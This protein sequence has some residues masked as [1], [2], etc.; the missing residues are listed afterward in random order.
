MSFFRDALR[1]LLRSPA[2][3]TAAIA[4][5][6]LGS[7]A[8]TAI[9][10][11]VDTTLVRPLPFPD[12]ERLA[13]VWFD[14]PGVDRRGSLSIPEA[15][16]LGVASSFDA[17]LVTSRVRAVVL[18]EDGAERLRGE[19]VNDGYFE[20]LGVRPVIGRLLAP[21]D[22]V[23]AAPSAI[24][25]SHGT[26]IRGFGGDPSVLG[27]TLRTERATYTVV[28]VAPRQFIGTIEQ[29]VVDFWIPLDKY[30]PQRL[31]RDRS[32]RY[33]WTIARLKPGI[34][35]A[36]AQDELNGIQQAW[37]TTYPG[38]YRQR[39][40]RIEPFGE[41]WRDGY[42]SAVGVLATAAGMLLA[43]AAINVGAL[44]LARV[45]DRRRELAVRAALGADRRRLVWL[46]FTEA[47]AIVVIGGALGACAGPLLLDSLL[48][49]SPVPLPEYLDL[50][51]NVGVLV[52]SCVALAV[53]GLFSGTAPALVGGRVG[54]GE[55]LKESGR[56]TAGR[57]VERRWLSV[58]IAAEVALTLTLLV[59]GGLLLRAYDRLASLDVGYRREG[60][61]RLAVTF[62]RADAGSAE[63]RHELL[64]RLRRALAAHPG[65]E[66]AGLVAPTLPPWDA[67]RAR[68]TFAELDPN[69]TPDGI[70][71]G[72]HL[73]DEGLLPTLGVPIVEGRNFNASD[74]PAGA[75]VV[76]V[77]RTLADRLGGLE[78]AVG[79]DITFIASDPMAP[80][81][82]YRVVG[83]AGDV[84]Y[85]GL[86]EQ[87]TQRYIHYT[88]AVDPRAARLDVYVPL[89]RFPV[90]QVSLAAFTR[91]D[92]AALVEP[93][94]RRIVEIAP[95]SA[96][97]WTGTMEDE[98]GLE[99]APTRFYALLVTLFSTSAL[100][101][102]SL[103]LFALLSHGAARRRGEMG[104]RL[105][106]GATPGNVGMLLVRSAMLPLAGG[107][108][109]GLA[110]AGWVSGAMRGL[111]YDVGSLDLTAF[112]A[113][114]A[115]LALVALTASLVPAR[116][117]ASIDPLIVLRE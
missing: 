21:G 92:P 54:P 70:E 96:V 80:S 99:Y 59:S 25:L 34:G 38:L 44:L 79:R 50:R 105:A 71:V 112:T 90:T 87:G 45:L 111:I 69:A 83:V 74:G 93:L 47:L 11:L 100:A 41:N 27:R 113:A 68:I 115:A 88:S 7:A 1:S 33:T 13:R 75:P 20:T 102:T 91:G 60:I 15:I 46:L 98:V 55:A 56:G 51:P 40:L 29:D 62:S 77:S 6:A 17:W 24:V 116:R 108:T 57:P 101:V 49:A 39:S 9:A 2:L 42:R 37:R 16:D 31:I 63:A 5:I 84:A 19:A 61:A 43:I 58:L 18:F 26:W 106:L 95:T 65:V 76:I 14:E 3:A 89:A 52:V 8:T 81:G 66:Q 30:E 86:A 73:I 94:R 82:R 10:T 67:D 4:C 110:G 78:R 72:S 109:G 22:H 97:H 114:I 104:V 53:A 48:A 35:M 117:V 23:A 64:A 28:G 32:Q 85:D 12:A 36:A 103:G 107:I